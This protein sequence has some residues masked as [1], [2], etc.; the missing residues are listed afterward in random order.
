MRMNEEAGA[1]EIWSV[2]KKQQKEASAPKAT[3]SSPARI[4]I[5]KDVSEL[6]E[7]STMKTVGLEEDPQ[8]FTLE[9][10]PDEGMYKGGTFKFRFKI[11]DAYPHEPPAVNCMQRI[12]HPNINPSGEVCLNILRPDWKPVLS[13]S[14]VFVGLQYLFL[15]PNADDPLNK[16]AAEVLRRN[17]AQFIQNVNAS[18]AGG[19]IDGVGFDDVRV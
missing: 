4:R 16:E 12:Y 7:Y 5:Q 14:S 19:S 2:K 8:N 3:K 15:E 1:D 13:L 6:E 18:M 11:P 17:R 10:S 9:I